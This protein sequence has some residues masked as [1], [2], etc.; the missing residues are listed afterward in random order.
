MFY[1]RDGALPVRARK[2]N[3]D[4]NGRDTMKQKIYSAGVDVG[5]TTTQMILSQL[6]VENTAGPFDPPHVE[7]TEKQVLYQSPIY[8]TPLC[9]DGIDIGAVE[10]ILSAEFLKSGYKRAD[11][12]S[13]AV[14]ITGESARKRNARAT[15]DVLSEQLGDFVVAEAGPDLES[16]LA[17]Q[18]AGAADFSKK[19]EKSVLNFDI[20]GGT[21]NACLFQAG[22]VTDAF[23]L[24]IGGRLV[25]LD[26]TGNVCYL[27]ERLAPL[28]DTYHLCIHSGSRVAFAELCRL[29]EILADCFLQLAGLKPLEKTTEALFIGHA[30]AP[31]PVDAVTF[32]G[33]VAECVYSGAHVESLME[34]AR[35][36][37]MGPLL[38]AKIRE[39]FSPFPQLFCEAVEK[40]RA[41][42]IGACNYS[43]Q[44]SGGTVAYDASVLPLKNLP[45]IR[46]SV[47]GDEKEWT[48][49]AEE[50]WARFG[51]AAAALAFEGPQNPS[52]ECVKQIAEPIARLFA[53]RNVPIVVVIENDF[54]KALGQVLRRSFPGRPVVCIDGIRARDGDYIDIGTPVAQV[55]PVVVKTLIFL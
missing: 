43:M 38:G 17:G 37:D 20:G 28:V 4:R 49:T 41:T 42:V 26:A 6:T 11:F 33:G 9:A 39:A 19:Q 15:V 22:V 53:A 7:I 36:G 46:V 5:T 14:I 2:E 12:S 30:Y 47:V 52:Y 25:R 48:Q 45:V 55:I 18:G 35:Y 54:A 34:T 8:F 21:T 44:V 50:K 1:K 23:A 24:D 10:Q 16:I 29:C 40:I 13:G 3:A 51:D 31:H 27:S 32:S